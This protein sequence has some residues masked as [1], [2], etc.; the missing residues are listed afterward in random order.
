MVVKRKGSKKSL[1]LFY[2]VLKRYGERGR[3]IL[4]SAYGELLKQEK[5]KALGM[6]TMKVAPKC[7]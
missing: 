4:K 2:G 3:E 1:E 7:T 5:I 6:N